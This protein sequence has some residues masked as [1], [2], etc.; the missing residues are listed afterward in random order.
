MRFFL[1]MSVLIGCFGTASAAVVLSDKVLT[2]TRTSAE[3]SALAYL[4]EPNGTGFDILEVFI[5][6]PDQALIA[7][8]DGYCFAAFRGTTLTKE[9][10]KQNLILGNEDI[11]TTTGSQER[12]CSTRRAFFQAYDT[13]YK[14]MLIKSLR[15]CAS[16]C[17][18]KDECVVLTG[19]SQGGA[20][21]AVAGVALADLNPYVITF[22]QPPTIDAPCAAITSERW[23]RYVNSKDSELLS[24]GIVYDP[25]PFAPGLGADSFGHMIMI[26]GDN[27]GVAYI[28]LD[29]QD[30][31]GPLNVKGFEAHSMIGAEGSKYPGYLDRIVAIMEYYAEKGTYPV[32]TTGYLPNSLCTEAKECETGECVKETGLSWARCVG[33]QCDEDMDCPETGRCDSGICVPKLG[34]CQPCD[35]DSDCESDHCTWHFVCTNMEGLIDN[36]CGCSVNSDCKSGR[37]EGWAPPICE[38]RL[39]DG[40]T[41]NEDSDCLSNDCSWSF[42]C[43]GGDKNLAIATTISAK[44]IVMNARSIDIAAKAHPTRVSE[45]TSNSKVKIGGVFGIVALAVIGFAAI[46]WYRHRRHGYEEIPAQIN[47]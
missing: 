20:V 18:N 3:L 36:E 16:A 26:S 42:R 6:E 1:A 33:T 19:H 43:R 14:D 15:S 8:K 25:I 22:G 21:A 31:F 30:F 37:C 47:V 39:G 10:W 7:S 44:Q 46:K 40:A 23:Y 29:A 27:S 11:C 24:F 5:D 4:P 32:R 9:D 34:S 13:T 17:K 12:C 35:E 38:A 41:C 2:L 28:G 45:P